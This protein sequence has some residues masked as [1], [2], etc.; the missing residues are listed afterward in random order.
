MTITITDYDELTIHVDD[1]WRE[2]FIPKF[3]IYMEVTEP[4]CYLY[5]TDTEKGASGIT[6][7]LQLDYDDVWF[8]YGGGTPSSAS[9]VELVIEGYQ[10]SAFSGGSVTV[11]ILSPLMLMGG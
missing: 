2:W 10:V 3:R 4:Y 8:G 6:R 1:G 11:D 9:E 5:W 7:M